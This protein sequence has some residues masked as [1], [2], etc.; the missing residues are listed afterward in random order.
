MFIIG[1]EARHATQKIKHITWKVDPFL[2]QIEPKMRPF[3][4]QSHKF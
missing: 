1:K 3:L 4:Y 2:Y